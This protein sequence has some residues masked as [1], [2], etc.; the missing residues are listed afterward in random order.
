MAKRGPKFLPP[1]EAKTKRLIVRISPLEDEIVKEA[2]QTAGETVS[3]YVMV[4]LSQ[5]M[6]GGGK[7]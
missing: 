4:A 3:E 7:C 6:N 1:G 5:R 2:A